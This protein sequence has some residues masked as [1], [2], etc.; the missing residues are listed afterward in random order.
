MLDGLPGAN[1]GAAVAVQRAQEAMAADNGS[2]L[3]TQW[4]LLQVH[5]AGLMGKVDFFRF[6]RKLGGWGKL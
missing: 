2:L 3:A 1:K 5:E 4:E 6:N